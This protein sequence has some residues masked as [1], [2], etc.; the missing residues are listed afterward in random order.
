MHALT[1]RCDYDDL[2][3]VKAVAPIALA[4]HQTR[5][6]HSLEADAELSSAFPSLSEPSPSPASLPTLVRVLSILPRSGLTLSR[7]PPTSFSFVRFQSLVRDALRASAGDVVA[8]Y[9]LGPSSC[10]CSL[11]FRELSATASSPRKAQSQDLAAASLLSL[12]YAHPTYREHFLLRVPDPSVTNAKSAVVNLLR[13]H[14]EWK[15]ADVQYAYSRLVREGEH[16]AGEACI[17]RYRGAALGWGAGG[18]R[19]EACEGAS[20]HVLT[21]LHTAR[22][23]IGHHGEALEAQLTAWWQRHQQRAQEELDAHPHDRSDVFSLGQL[24]LATAADQTSGN[25]FV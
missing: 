9:S 14:S 7:R 13:A 16:I 2:G 24:L 15:G 17:V 19:R 20:R 10:T 5:C 25:A 12:L 8:S 18:K 6:P 4:T 11:T 1:A 3:C 22:A 21:Q 23:L